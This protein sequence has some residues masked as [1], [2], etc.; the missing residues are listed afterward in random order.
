MGL[1]RNFVERVFRSRKPAV[2]QRVVRLAAD[3]GD[4][5]FV[6]L[7]GG[8]KQRTRELSETQ[9]IE[10]VRQSS[11]LYESHGT[12]EMIINRMH[13]FVFEKG[14]DLSLKFAPGIPDE[15]QAL[16]EKRMF[17]Q[18]WEDEQVAIQNR[19]TVLIAESAIEGEYGVRVR[20][21]PNGTV[22]YGEVRTR[23]IVEVHL[24]DFDPLQTV[25]L[26]MRDAK[27][28]RIPLNV[29][30]RV[31][32][33]ERA[34]YGYLAGDVLWY[35]L[36]LR[37]T[38][39]RGRSDLQAIIDE[40]ADDKAFRHVA[41]QKVLD[42]MTTFMDVLLEGM[43]DEGVKEWMKN[44]PTTLAEVS[45]LIRYH[46]ETVTYKPQ[47]V[48]M[49]AYEITQMIKTNAAYPL[50][51]KGYP[52]SWFAFGD[53]TNYATAKAQQFPV[54]ADFDS[55]QTSVREFLRTAAQHALD[56]AI[57]SR[58]IGTD[59]FTTEVEIAG[60]KV[61]VTMPL[62][63]GVTIEITPRALKKSDDETPFAATTALANA[64]RT[65][66]VAGPQG[67]PL[68]SDKDTLFLLNAAL[69][70]DGVGLVIAEHEDDREAQG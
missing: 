15:V 58:W 45:G 2:A 56:Q 14:F 48:D 6:E 55:R 12:A 62:R 54:F 28:Q 27:N 16:I 41:A 47:T 37:K 53:G 20:T 11:L 3:A 17:L 26:V 57:L 59:S 35:K 13:T 22:S 69:Q 23:E 50:G 40:L 63:D 64:L 46:N 66:L 38:Q 51:T 43:S 42:G 34:D 5:G 44:N 39:P 31:S 67:A 7:S 24:D 68:L 29:V 52:L 70:Q 61:P 49:K 8:R 30:R 33:T 19:T 1:V 10:V 32:N 60:R 18:Y 4:E 65:F 21:W 9:R 25:M 36:G